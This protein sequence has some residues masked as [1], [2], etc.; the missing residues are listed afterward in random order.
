MLEHVLQSIGSV[1][2]RT[3]GR[4][5]YGRREHKSRQ[6]AKENE[7][8]KFHALGLSGLDCKSLVEAVR[9]DTALVEGD[10]FLVRVRIETFS[11][12]ESDECDPIFARQIDREAARRRNGA[13][14]RNAGGERFLHDLEA[15]PS[16]HH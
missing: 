16:A 15:A 9:R 8:L 2:P 6:H 12:K 10:P 3:S 11:A 13:D 14:D 5:Q 7:A 4:G 1:G